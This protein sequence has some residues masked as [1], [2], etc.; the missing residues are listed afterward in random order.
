LLN[1]NEYVAMSNFICTTCGTQF[2]ETDQPPN[3][4][5]IC[6][7]ERQYVG[8]SGQQWTTLDDLRDSH[9]NVV[10]L[11]ELALYGV[12]CPGPASLYDPFGWTDLPM[13]PPD[14]V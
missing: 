4:C 7:D 5:S 3:E 10:R 2:D 11:E 8:W 13:P 14:W 12:G 1:L 9:R 6:T